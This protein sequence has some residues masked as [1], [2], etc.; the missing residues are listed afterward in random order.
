MKLTY[1]NLNGLKTW[2]NDEQAYG[3]IAI[4]GLQ[5]PKAMIQC[6]SLPQMDG[7]IFLQSKIEQ[8]NIVL[9]LQVLSDAE[10]NRR[11]LY[12]I[13]KI[14]QKGTVTIALKEQT[15]SI[16]A[17]CESIEIVPMAWPLRAIISLICPQPYFETEDSVVLEMSSI[18][19]TLSFPLALSSTGFPIGTLTPATAINAVNSG[20]IPCGFTVRFQCTAPVENPKL[21]HMTT[22][23]N[24]QLMLTMTPGQIIE[25]QTDLGHKRIEEIQGSLRINR[26]NTLKLG[27]TFFQLKEKDNILFAT[28][29]SGSASL[30]TELTYRPKISG[31]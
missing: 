8:R 26:F 21:I 25:I 18:E 29:D 30:L 31:V 11:R 16:D 9:T 23:E 3:L 15:V 14:K 27:S 4:Q 28:S 6:G 22:G 12:D 19:A 5:P 20:D 10:V 7:S 1:T 17:I 2:I 13:F 24:I